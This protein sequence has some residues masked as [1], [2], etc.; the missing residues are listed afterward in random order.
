MSYCGELTNNI[1]GL[2]C[3][4]PSVAG[5]NGA[6][7]YIMNFDDIDRSLSVVSAS[8]VI[9]SLVLNS[10]KYAYLIE[11]DPD[12]IEPSWKEE[13]GAYRRDQFS[14][15]MAIKIFDQSPTNKQRIVD[16]AK[17]KFVVV[18]ERNGIK[19]NPTAPEVKGDNVYEAWGWDSGLVIGAETASDYQ[20]ADTGGGINLQLTT[21]DKRKENRPPYSVF[22]TSLTVTIAMLD[23]LLEPASP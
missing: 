10:G 16:L 18:L 4:N 3:N 19:N 8:G 5:V 13:P 11:T 2:D 9:S 6:R 15:Q 23:A 22:I 14:Q 20:D 7:G 21:S 17:G 1:A 12:G